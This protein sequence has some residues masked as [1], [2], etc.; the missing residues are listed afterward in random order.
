MGALFKRICEF[1][2]C[3]IGKNP[4]RIIGTI[5]EQSVDIFDF[6]GMLRSIN[7]SSF[8]DF[9]RKLSRDF[10]LI[11]LALTLKNQ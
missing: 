9:N 10:A 3:M 11:E 8:V 1:L 5:L 2:C 7:T 6:F 4:E